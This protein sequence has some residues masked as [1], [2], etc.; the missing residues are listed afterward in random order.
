MWIPVPRRRPGQAPDVARLPVGADE[1][2]GGLI[3]QTCR[4]P[5]LP[6]ACHDLAETGGARLR[7]RDEPSLEG[8]TFA[9]ALHASPTASVIGLAP[10]DG[11]AVL[12]PR[13]NTVLGRDDALVALLPDG[14]G[15]GPGGW[16]GEIVEEAVQPLPAGSRRPSRTLMLGW[17]LRAP[18]VVR[19]LDAHVVPGSRLDVVAG[20][21]SDLSL[22]T[23][24]LERLDMRFSLG[25]TRGLT[26]LE[27]MEPAT[28]D[29]VIV[30]CHGDR[31]GEGTRATLRRLRR[32]RA[33]SGRTFA[34]VG[35][36]PGEA[37]PERPGER[38]ADDFLVS[39]GLLGGLL[40]RLAANPNLAGLF[41]PSGTELHVRKA[42]GYVRPGIEI[43]FHTVIEA[44]RRRGDVAIGY[45]VGAREPLAPNAG[46]VVNPDKSQPLTFAAGDGLIVLTGGRRARRLRKG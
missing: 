45:R 8:R 42:T 4:E 29:G 12:R 32:I 41:A 5:G 25:D 20:A 18:A 10:G 21:E 26:S 27:S 31:D 14:G 9:E 37:V 40:G 1:L 6:V 13:M 36:V 23:A 7:V 38:G 17:N 28:Y 19:W 46:V 34:I 44:A 43:D 16:T 11:D 39:D 15:F 22:V 30:L 33:E 35:E 3:A 24:G 2:A